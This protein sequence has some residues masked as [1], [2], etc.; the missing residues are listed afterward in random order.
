MLLKDPLLY[1]TSSCPFHFLSTRGC[2]RRN[3]FD[4][5]VGRNG[6][7][8]YERE[9]GHLDPAATLAA[10]GL[11]WWLVSL[12]IDLVEIDGGC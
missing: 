5:F 11:S 12:S 1:A 6:S 10:I 3:C 9:D 8:Q 4:G 7:A 2:G